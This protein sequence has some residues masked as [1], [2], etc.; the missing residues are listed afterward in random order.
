[1]FRDHR[2]PPSNMPYPPPF[3]PHLPPP[4]FTMPPMPGF[5]QWPPGQHS[6]QQHSIQRPFMPTPPPIPGRASPYEYSSPVRLT[7][8]SQPWMKDNRSN[9]TMQWNSNPQQPKPAMPMQSQNETDKIW[10]QNFVHKCKMSSECQDSSVKSMTISQVRDL[11]AKAC[12]LTNELK[13][14]SSTNL[15]DPRT[16]IVKAELD[17]VLSKLSDEAM[18]SN[19][20]EKLRKRAK[21]RQK[22]KEKRKSK[23]LEKQQLQA[24][25]E[26]KHK[27]FDEWVRKQAELE[28]RQ[29]R[30]KEVQKQL[31]KH[32]QE[33]SQ[34]KEKLK[35][36]LEMINALGKL[37]KVRKESAIQKGHQQ[38]SETHDKVFSNAHSEAKEYIVCT[39]AKFNQ[40][41]KSLRSFLEEEQK[42]EEDKI[43]KQKSKVE[44]EKHNDWN[45]HRWEVLFGTHDQL[46][47]FD[48][49]WPIQELHKQA[50]ST[51]FALTN[52]RQ[53]WDQFI[54]SSGTRIPTKWLEPPVSTDDGWNSYLD[55][56]S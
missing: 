26:Q 42:K 52:T 5:Q 10:L 46:N 33:I 35:K 3:S 49:M 50:S 56:D 2:F 41:E 13:G 8:P 45:K 38:A 17:K 20:S 32:L 23:Y 16:S 54:S 48:S 12:E 29:K 6:T 18:V 51:L 21:K 15:D 47:A 1:M 53:Q 36:S 37:R 9:L 43:K 22:M 25:L 39:L 11:H 27:E 4:P 31:D 14:L 7:P 24:E 55:D 19:L 40:E 30:E 34:S 28:Q 44:E